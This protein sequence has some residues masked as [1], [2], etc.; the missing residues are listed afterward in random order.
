M[1]YG[2]AHTKVKLS[3]HMVK[4][5]FTTCDLPKHK[6]RMN[7]YLAGKYY[8]NKIDKYFC[9]DRNAFV[10]KDDTELTV[11]DFDS[12]EEYYDYFEAVKARKATIGW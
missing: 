4:G 9:I 8:R 3:L 12:V 5:R 1:T 6:A 2:E 11:K 7:K 10:E